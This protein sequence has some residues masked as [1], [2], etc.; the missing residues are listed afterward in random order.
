MPVFVEF[1]LLNPNFEQ[2][3]FDPIQIGIIE[4]GESFH[5]QTKVF[6]LSDETVFDV[7]SQSETVFIV[8]QRR[9]VVAVVAAATNPRFFFVSF[10]GGITPPRAAHSRTSKHDTGS[11]AVDFSDAVNDC[12][13]QQGYF[14]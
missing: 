9:V 14:F 7:W 12:R 3:A 1:F 13:C 2:F 8:A 11:F 5:L 6:Y 4:I 10:P